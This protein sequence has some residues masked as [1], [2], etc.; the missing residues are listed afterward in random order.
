LANACH[1]NVKQF[2]KTHKNIF[3]T[4]AQGSFKLMYKKM[5]VNVDN[6]LI[7]KKNCGQKVAHDRA[8]WVKRMIAQK[9]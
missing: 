1:Q 8:D 9:V 7:K 2:F 5:L 6:G 3:A 4:D